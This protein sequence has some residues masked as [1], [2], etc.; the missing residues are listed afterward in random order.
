MM[1][2]QRVRQRFYAGVRRSV[3]YNLFPLLSRP[4]FINVSGVPFPLGVTGTVAQNNPNTQP[5][6]MQ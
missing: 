1:P 4:V 3:A 5:E 2:L 6:E